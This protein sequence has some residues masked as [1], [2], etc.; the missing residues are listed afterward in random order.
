LSAFT[1]NPRNGELAIINRAA[2]HGTAPCHVTVDT[3]HNQP[4]LE[5][6]PGAGPR[7]F[8]FHPKGSCA[9]LINE[10]DSTIIS[11]E[12]EEKSGTLATNRL[13]ENAAKLHDRSERDLSVRGESGH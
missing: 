4:W 12:Y 3:G 9:Y 2:T 5:T 13:G 7:H 6:K 10:L 8:V 1:L 11:L